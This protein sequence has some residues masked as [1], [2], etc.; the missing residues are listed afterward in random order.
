M[1]ICISCNKPI[2]EGRC[3]CKIRIIAN[4]KEDEKITYIP[5]SKF[6]NLPIKNDK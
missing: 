6:T 2:S 3:D 5:I 1:L 4:S